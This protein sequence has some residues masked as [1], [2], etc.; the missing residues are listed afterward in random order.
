[1]KTFKR[2]HRFHSVSTP[3]CED[4]PSLSDLKLVN[5]YKVPITQITS[6]IEKKNAQLKMNKNEVYIYMHN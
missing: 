3:T 6:L 4:I 1:M 2:L 5:I